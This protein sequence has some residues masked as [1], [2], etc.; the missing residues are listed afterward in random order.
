MSTSDT[1]QLLAS[2][3]RTISV[4]GKAARYPESLQHRVVEYARRRIKNRVP[5]ARIADSIALPVQT[6]ERWLSRTEESNHDKV[7][8][9]LQPSFSVIPVVVEPTPSNTHYSI[10]CELA[11][12]MRVQVQG[13]AE[14]WFET[15]AR[16]RRPS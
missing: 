15:I 6:L 3:I 12:G 10:A 9:S 5:L 4:R 7:D 11:D 16:L 8:D 1:A 14:L 13:D 2:E